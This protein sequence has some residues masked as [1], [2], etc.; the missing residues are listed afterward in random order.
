MFKEA[1]LSFA[2]SFSTSSPLSSSLS[3]QDILGFKVGD[4]F[5]AL[6]IRQNTIDDDVG[7][8]DAPFKTTSCSMGCWVSSTLLVQQF[9]DIYAFLSWQQDIASISSCVLVKQFLQ[10]MQGISTQACETCRV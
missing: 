10:D 6:A 2:S 7:S 8:L 4:T 3:S 9:E 5:E 1:T